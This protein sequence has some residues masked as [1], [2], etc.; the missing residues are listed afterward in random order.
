MDKI[1]TI[2]KRV[3]QQP[4]QMQIRNKLECFQKEVGGLIEI[5][6]LPNNILM[7]M[8][9]EGKFTEKPNFTLYLT[10]TDNKNIRRDHLKDII[11]GNV[12]FVADTGDD[13]GSL[14]ADQREYIVNSFSNMGM[15]YEV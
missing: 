10:Y 15:K 9:E 12:L 6:T 13:F 3:D 11:H 5:M 1:M 14:K 7:I 8:N 2:V 4:Q